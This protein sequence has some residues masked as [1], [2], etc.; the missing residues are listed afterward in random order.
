VKDLDVKPADART[1][2]R[3]INDGG[4]HS[5]SV[6]PRSALER[7]EAATLRTSSFGYA[8]DRQL[9]MT[10]KLISAVKSPSFKRVKNL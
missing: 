6:L 9:T 10:G 7:R 1:R 2:L 3:P 8:R 5:T 4:S